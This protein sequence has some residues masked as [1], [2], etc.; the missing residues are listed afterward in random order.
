MRGRV[1]SR[2]RGRAGIGC[3][4]PA[5]QRRHDVRARR[6]SPAQIDVTGAGADRVRH[7]V[8]QGADL[9][10]AVAGPL[11]SLGVEAERDIVDEDPT[12]DLGE[13]HP[14]LT[15]STNASSA[16]TT[17]SRS[18]PR[19]SAKWLRVP[20]GTHAYGSPSSAATLATTAC[21]PSPPAIARP[22][23]PRSTAP[24]TSTSRSSPGFSSIGRCHV[25]SLLGELEAFGLPAAG[26]RIEEKHRSARRLRVRQIHM[27]RKGGARCRQRHQEA[28]DDQQI[29]PPLAARD[30]QGDRADE[31]D[32]SDDHPCNPRDAPPTQAVPGGPAGDQHTA[33]KNRPRGNWFI[34]TATAKASVAIPTTSARSPSAVS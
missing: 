7:S 20:A 15:P 26:A 1:P 8:Q 29:N 24:R 14:T 32:A 25:T 3:S 2:P 21:E 6:P 17:S 33:Q 5:L 11:N 19:S 16:P 30:N 28:H 10:V 34:A 13:V 4:R 18:T 31:R 22:S 23:A 9:G 12:V 27:D